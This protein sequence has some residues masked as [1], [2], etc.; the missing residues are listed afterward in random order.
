M[1]SPLVSVICLCYNHSR[2]VKEAVESVL[3]QTYQNIQLILVDDA[4]TDNS[5]DV[6]R[7]ILETNPSIEFIPITQNMGNCKA[8]NRGL[9]KAKGEYI[10]DLAADDIMIPGKIERQVNHFLLLPESYGVVFTDAV[11]VDEWGNYL[12]DHFQYLFKKKLIDQVPQGDVYAKV[13]STYFIP[14]PTM[15]VRAS[16]FESLMGYDENLAYEDFDFWIRSSRNFNY[17]FLNEK[18]MKIRRTKKSM[19]SGWYKNDDPQLLSTY[20]ICRKAQALNRDVNDW[21]AWV[22]RVRYELKQSVFSE[23][24]YE[25]TLFFGLLLEVN[26]VSWR[27]KLIYWLDSFHLPLSI[28]RKWYHQIRF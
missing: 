2:F 8:F 4:S 21:Q 1:S 10:I 9:A 16:V 23:N 28:L 14:S 17:S 27:Y 12:R 5:V 26:Q 20:Q 22:K 3:N 25:A 24:H 15:M 7:Q 6:I 18:L 11:Y 19:S 13:L